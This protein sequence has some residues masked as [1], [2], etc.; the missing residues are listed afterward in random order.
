MRRRGMPGEEAVARKGGQ[1]Y[2]IGKKSPGSNLVAM[3]S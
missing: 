3:G 2:L 1:F